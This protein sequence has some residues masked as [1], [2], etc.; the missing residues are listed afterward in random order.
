MVPF[1]L[2]TVGAAEFSPCS[3]TRQGSQLNQGCRNLDY[4]QNVFLI[5]WC[6]WSLPFL[7][8]LLN[9]HSE[10][11][12]MVLFVI[13]TQSSRSVTSLFFLLPQN[14]AVVNWPFYHYYFFTC[15]N[16]ILL[17]K[18]KEKKICFLD[19]QTLV[20]N[21]RFSPCC[22]Q[23]QTLDKYWTKPALAASLRSCCSTLTFFSTRTPPPRTARKQVGAWAWTQPVRPLKEK[24]RWSL[25]PPL[26]IVGAK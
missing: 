1:R 21:H 17:L 10:Y 19:L 24:Q 11:Q 9:F 2:K 3:P 18:K 16:S 12:A 20:E 7:Q 26:S 22:L 23:V 5:T 13:L 14:P 6:T 15:S 8:L 4:F 25:E